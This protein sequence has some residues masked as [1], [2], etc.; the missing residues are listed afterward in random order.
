M[1]TAIAL[2]FTAGRFHATQWGRHVNEG[3]PEWP[4]SPWRVLRAL[5]AVW[6]R[7]L[8]DNTECD[9]LVVKPLL[10]KLSAPPL[11]ILPPSGTGHTRHYMPTNSKKTKVFDVFVALGRQEDVVFIW[12]DVS[13][14]AKERIALS[15][16]IQNL[17][18]LGRAESWCEGRLLGDDEVAKLISQVNC[19]PLGDDEV[20][21]D[22][23]IVR[24]L[25]ADPV[26]AF[27]ND[28]TP[29]IKSGKTNIPLYE[30]DWHLCMETLELHKQRWSDPPG[31]DW[32]PYVRRSDC[33]TVKRE[34]ASK[35][36]APPLITTARYVID[37]PV[38]PLV[39]DTL[40]VAELARRYLMGSYRR[41]EERRLRAEGIN[42]FPLPRS[43]V[44]SGKN[45]E[46]QPL[47]DHGHAYFLPTDEDN[48]GRLDHITI[49]AERGFSR[50]ELA[51]IDCLRLLNR[52]PDLPKLDLLLVDLGQ[53][54]DIRSP[55]SAESRV[56]TSRTPFLV[57][58]H[59][60]TRGRKRDAPE[61]LGPENRLHFV[62]A[63]LREELGRLAERRDDIPGIRGIIVEPLEDNRIGARGLRSIQFKRSRAKRGDDGARRAA[64]GFRIIFP[65]PVRG[66][67]CLGHSAHFGLGMF[68]PDSW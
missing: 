16:L 11:F 68:F 10:E 14:S 42:D 3:V 23:E 30:P 47:K 65:E 55:L 66:P 15:L 35:A 37:S 28:H 50:L 52:G 58:R 60:K 57:N 32:A 22:Q 12:P 62:Q 54:N 33:F 4:P 34:Y 5:V 41:Y 44:F 24:V 6:K 64:G 9:L 51:V 49:I 36:A 45:A 29:K 38:L 63:V 26:T 17:G 67:I 27:K 31:A 25:C 48:D 53:N 61:L 56:W 46:G 18:F 13:L 43:E 8:D 2:R 7:K 40:T 21:S 39:Q 1:V 59:Q 19:R 20:G